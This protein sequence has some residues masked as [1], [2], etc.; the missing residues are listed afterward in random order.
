MTTPQVP[1]DPAQR[2]VRLVGH[3]DSNRGKFTVEALRASALEAGYAADEIEAAIHLAE[4]RDAE[5]QASA[6]IRSSARMAILLAY[7]IVWIL[8]AVVYLGRPF[9]YGAGP[10][11]QL[12]LTIALGIGLAI[13]L[14][15]IRSG[16]PD[17]GRR[18]R[19][20]GLLLAV[21]VILLVGV[22]GLCLPFTTMT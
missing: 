13:S 3:F 19:A 6:P 14:L 8:F 1:T 7:G 10:I 9:A 22:A 4:V 12:I 11:A 15:I 16:R 21:P 17:P 5:R 2:Q 18:T 20:M